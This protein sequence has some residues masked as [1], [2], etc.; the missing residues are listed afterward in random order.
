MT[1][2]T[3]DVQ[4]PHDDDGQASNGQAN[5]RNHRAAVYLFIHAQDARPGF[6]AA[7]GNQAEQPQ[8]A[9]SDTS[10]R[11]PDKKRMEDVASV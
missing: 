2:P 1:E 4:A 8:R 3:V 5:D 11:A 10:P 6:H 9:A 7:S